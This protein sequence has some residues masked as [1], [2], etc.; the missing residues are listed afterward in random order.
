MYTGTS[1]A[2]LIRVMPLIPIEGMGFSV[3]NYLKINPVIYLLISSFAGSV[4][5][6]LMFVF[7][8]FL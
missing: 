8:S 3:V 1:P 5:S 4:K 2:E 6:K 7:S